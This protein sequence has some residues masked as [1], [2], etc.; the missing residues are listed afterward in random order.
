MGDRA[1][2]EFCS[3][4]CEFRASRCHSD[5]RYCSQFEDCQGSCCGEFYRA[6]VVLA[7]LQVRRYRSP[8]ECRPHQA[9]NELA[10]TLTCFAADHHHLI[11]LLVDEREKFPLTE[12]LTSTVSCMD[13]TVNRAHLTFVRRFVH[14]ESRDTAPFLTHNHDNTCT[15]VVGGERGGREVRDRLLTLMS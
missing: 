5:C 13:D 7:H 10:R 3:P 14:R 6:S 8:I 2:S 12:V 1:C 15:D 9:V 4:C 11:S